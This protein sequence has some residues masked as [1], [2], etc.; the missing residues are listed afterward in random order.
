MGKKDFFDDH[1]DQFMKLMNVKQKSDDKEEK[2]T[3]ECEQKK[4]SNG[5]IYSSS[6]APEKMRKSIKKKCKK[7]DPIKRK[8]W[9]YLVW[10]N[11][12]VSDEQAQLLSEELRIVVES[13]DAKLAKMDKE[14]KLQMN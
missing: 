7:L 11:Q 3:K 4:C 9:Y 5:R 8:I 6:F 10:W 12:F 13:V 14:I 2:K 1:A